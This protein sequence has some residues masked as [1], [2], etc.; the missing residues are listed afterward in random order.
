MPVYYYYN[1]SFCLALEY[2][3][4]VPFIILEPILK[5]AT[6]SQLYMLEYHNHYLIEDTGELWKFH[7]NKEFRSRISE[8]DETET[9]RQFYIVIIKYTYAC[10]LNNNI[11]LSRFVLYNIS[12]FFLNLI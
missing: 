6:P 4:G 1:Y 12:S 2:T 5:Y 3:G 10:S 9:W 8:K 11:L 7:S